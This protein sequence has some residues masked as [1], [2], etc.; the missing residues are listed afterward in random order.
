MFL[1]RVCQPYDRCAT[2]DQGR[3]GICCEGAVTV[4]ASEMS[5]PSAADLCF[6]LEAGASVSRPETPAR[7]EKQAARRLRG[8]FRF[9]F[10]THPQS[11]SRDR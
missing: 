5:S 4:C 9:G 2:A 8:C 1:G 11:G 3:L 7:D 6:C 10:A